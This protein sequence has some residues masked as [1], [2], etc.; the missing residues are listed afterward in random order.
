[1]DARLPTRSAVCLPGLQP[2]CGGGHP[3]GTPSVALRLRFGCAAT[4]P[5][6]NICKLLLILH[7]IVRLEW[8]CRDLNPQ[9]FDETVDDTA[10]LAQSVMRRVRAPPGRWRVSCER[11]HITA[12]HVMVHDGQCSL[13]LVQ[14]GEEPVRLAGQ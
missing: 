2:G 3:G 1:M 10:S 13:R 12:T 9:L 4:H 11:I 5:S 6:S 8:Y 7:F 14:F